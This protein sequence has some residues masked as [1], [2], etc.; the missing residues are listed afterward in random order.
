MFA[1]ADKSR[2]IKLFDTESRECKVQNFWQMHTSTVNSI[3]F[4][5]N[6]LYLA[7][8]GVDASIMIWDCNKKTSYIKGTSGHVAGG[9]NNITWVDDKTVQTAGLDSTIRRFSVNF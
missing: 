6:D 9:I 5:P 8:A 7:S 1:T 4:S 3:E 2:E